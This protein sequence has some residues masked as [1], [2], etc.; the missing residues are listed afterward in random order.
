MPVMAAVLL[1][2]VLVVVLLLLNNV[3]EIAAETPADDDDDD[4]N[5]Y[6]QLFLEIKVP[7]LG[8]LCPHDSFGVD[9]LTGE[10]QSPRH[11]NNYCDNLDCSYEVPSLFSF[12]ILRAA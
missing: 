8:C 12:I 9:L 2:V 3:A 11:P 4:D 7:V 10:F 5:G 1:S 6:S